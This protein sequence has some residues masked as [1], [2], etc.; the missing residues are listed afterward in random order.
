LQPQ[1]LS[2]DAA[3]LIFEMWISDLIAPQCGWAVLAKVKRVLSSE[4]IY[5]NR[6]SNGAVISRWEKLT[7]LFEPDEQGFL[8]RH[9]YRN[10]LGYQCD[11]MFERP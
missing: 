10:E 6:G 9:N 4:I 2:T 8:Y 11:I 3:S 7:L 5:T 1:A